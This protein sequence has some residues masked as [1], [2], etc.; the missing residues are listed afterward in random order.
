MILF[1]KASTKG[2]STRMRRSMFGMG[3]YCKK[4]EPPGA[5]TTRARAREKVR[6][7]NWREKNTIAVKAPRSPPALISLPCPF[8]VMRLPK[9]NRTYHGHHDEESKRI[10][11]SSC[12]FS[13]ALCRHWFCREDCFLAGCSRNRYVLSCCSARRSTPCVC[14]KAM[15]C[16]PMMIPKLLFV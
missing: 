14:G 15:M 12:F 6:G 3:L 4:G 10:N 16:S 7:G 9:Q 1:F 13:R 11:F 2:Y 8:L 5:L